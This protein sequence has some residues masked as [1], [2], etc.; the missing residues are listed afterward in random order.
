MQQ[1]SRL[2]VPL[3][4]SRESATKDVQRWFVRHISLE[5]PPRT[6][7]PSHKLGWDTTTLM[8]CIFQSESVRD[9]LRQFQ[10][11]LLQVTNHVC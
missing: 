2:Q 6:A 10:I 7:G 4:A 1:F 8:V 5:M 3:Q 11:V 9:V